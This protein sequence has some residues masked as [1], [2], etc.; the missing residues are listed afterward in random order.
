MKDPND[1]P[2]LHLFE[3]FNS[4]LGALATLVGTML[5]QAVSL[6]DFLYSQFPTTLILLGFPLHGIS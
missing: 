4:K 1:H 5:I 2:L 3:C 6:C